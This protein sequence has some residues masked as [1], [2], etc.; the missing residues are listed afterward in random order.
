MFPRKAKSLPEDGG[1]SW[2]EKNFSSEV[3]VN[4]GIKGSGV[5]SQ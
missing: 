3:G 1:I 5:I 2:N 4:C